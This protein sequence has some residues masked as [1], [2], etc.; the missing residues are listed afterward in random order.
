MNSLQQKYNEEVAPALQK[1]FGIKNVFQ[2]PKL[3][4][5]VVNVG[6]SQPAEAR[7]RRQVLENVSQQLELITGQKAQ[8]TT[9][10]KAIANFKTRVGDPLGTCVTL[11]GEYMWEFL[12]KLINIALPR[13][14]DF[15]GVSRTAFDKQGN[16]SLGLEEQIIFPEIEYDKIDSVRS[17]QVN[18]VTNTK[19]DDQALK[20]L[21]LL[22]MPFA[23]EATGEK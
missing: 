22:G 19:E 8:I 12:Q 11:R 7:A 4:K 2:I 23:K 5:I 10:K 17:L 20:M 14:K 9:A 3:K 16:Y 18:F 13:V 15:T 1:Q 6:V 21:E